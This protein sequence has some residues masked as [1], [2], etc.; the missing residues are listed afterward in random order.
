MSPRQYRSFAR[1]LSEHCAGARL[2]ARLPDLLFRF[3][4]L[5]A[6]LSL[7]ASP[8]LGA[9]VGIAPGVGTNTSTFTF[10]SGGVPY[11]VIGPTPVGHYPTPTVSGF[12]PDP[13]TGFGEMDIAYNFTPTAAKVFIPDNGPVAIASQGAPAP[14]AGAM[15]S[16]VDFSVA[17]AIDAGGTPATVIS[18]AYPIAFGQSAPG[19]FNSFDAVVLYTSTALGILGSSEVHFAFA[20]GPGGS[21]Y[22]VVPDIGPLLLPALPALDTLTLSGSFVLVAD[23]FAG[24]STEIE[25]FGVPE[26]SSWLLLALGATA[27][28]ASVRRRKRG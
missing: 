9:I 18:V 20:G 26:P 7:V 27:V 2:R 10:S 4:L 17:F 3:G 11:A 8:A 23:G 6:V 1:R 25:V 15:E 19:M 28:L 24:G 22:F 16:K 5:V 13:P 14:L 12:V 21:P